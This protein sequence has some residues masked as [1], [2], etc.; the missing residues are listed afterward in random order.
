MNRLS[1][2][3]RG[4]VIA[5]LVEGMSIRGI[6]RATGVAKNTI[7]KLLCDLGQACTEHQDI[8][9]RDLTS[10]RIECDETWSFCYAKQKHVPEQFQDT[11]GYGDVWTWTAIDADTKLVPSW[12]VGERTSRDAW[13]FLS[14]LHSRL[15]N[16]VQLTTDGHK[17]YLIVI[18]PLFGAD[19][20]DLA[21]LHKMYGA[22]GNDSPSTPTARPSAPGSTTD[23]RGRAPSRT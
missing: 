19:G 16:R 10:E 21:M 8:H 5:L 1:T 20:V 12:L 2:E 17:P 9:L 13:Y 23:N 22:G 3:R 7:V 4:Q 6:V 14:D 15:R 11:P 18:E